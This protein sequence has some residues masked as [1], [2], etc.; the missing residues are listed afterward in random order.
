MI[1]IKKYLNVNQL[2]N[3]EIISESGI[4]SRYPS[5]VEN[6]REDG[7]ILVTPL[8]DRYPVYL[9]P[10]TKLNVIFWDKKAV[11]TFCT[12]LLKNIEGPVYFLMVTI[13]ESIE[14]VQKREFVRVELVFEVLLT[15]KN[16]ENKEVIISC[17]S[18]DISGGG[19]QLAVLKTDLPE[20]GSEV[21]LE[22]TLNNK[23]I[24][25]NGILV[26]NKRN[27]DSD[28]KERN[29][30]AIKFSKILEVDRTLI[31]KEVYLRQIE[32]RRKGLL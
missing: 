20:T 16:R 1:E 24:K 15:Y 17:Q 31:I 2:V 23:L 9:P 25:A 22:F 18:K 4:P 6:L 12:S 29:I 30:L 21:Q 14:R 26:W 8:K 19:L 11:Y 32:L 13:P 7:I 28:G 5:R 27:T 10:G 3:I